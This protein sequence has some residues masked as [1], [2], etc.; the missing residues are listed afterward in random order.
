MGQNF[1]VCDRERDLEMPRNVEQWLP[2]EHVCWKVLD[3]VGELDL[4]AFDASYRVDRQGGAAYPPATLIALILYCYSKGVRSSPRIEQACWDDVGRRVI[5]ANRRVDHSTVARFIRRHRDAFASLFVQ[6]LALCGRRGLVDLSAVAVD[7]SPME[8][9][10]SRRSNQRLE[11]LEATIFQCEDEINALMNEALD[12][13]RTVEAGALGGIETGAVSDDWPRLS[14]L[15]DRLTRARLARDRIYERALPSANEIRI[16]VEAAERMVARAE[17]RLATE[18]AAH[19]EKLRKHEARTQADVTA[20]RRGANGRPPVPMESKTVLIRQRARLEKAREG[21]ERAR[22]PQPVPSPQARACPSDPD[23]RMMLSKRGA[24]L[25]RY[26]V[27]IVC[28]RRQ[29]LLSI[30][31]CR[32]ARVSRTS[33]CWSPSPAR[34]TWQDSPPSANAPAVVSTPWPTDCLLQMVGSSIAN[35]VLWS[36]QDSPSSSNGSAATSTTAAPGR[37][38]RTQAPRHG[39][40]P[41]QA[42]QTHSQSLL[43]TFAKDELCDSLP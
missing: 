35:A 18:T 26:N 5:T 8:A 17:K 39:P 13:A 20:G 4:S 10:A 43:L 42:G 31:A 7:G 30:E 19:R 23:S 40:Q 9:N 33:R 12:H 24:Y 15:C 21:L 25:Q 34:L 41:Q 28:A 14:Q 3:V 29:I 11:H 27:Q 36:S 2:P 1:L 16:K 37:G 22:N 38:H 32:R 6:V